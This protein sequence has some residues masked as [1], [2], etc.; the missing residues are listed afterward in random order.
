MIWG[1]VGGSA[2]YW[3]DG[4]PWKSW[5][6]TG[7]AG[8]ALAARDSAAG[9]PLKIDKLQHTDRL[10]NVPPVLKKIVFAP[11]YVTVNIYAH[12]ILTRVSEWLTRII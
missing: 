11:Q 8:L 5:L 1:L 4:N 2:Q 9:S 10:C 6:V 3:T 7:G 12:V